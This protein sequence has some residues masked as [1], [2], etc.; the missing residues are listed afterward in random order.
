MELTQSQFEDKVTATYYEM[1]TDKL[2][3]ELEDFFNEEGI[4]ID[5]EV[6]NRLRIVVK[7]FIK[8]V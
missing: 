3:K 2:V 4:I 8:R 5:E 6:E 1:M 7:S